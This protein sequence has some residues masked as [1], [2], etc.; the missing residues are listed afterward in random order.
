MLM[1]KQLLLFQSVH[2]VI[3]AE[4]YLEKKGIKTKIIAVPKS[5]SSECG[6]CLIFENGRAEEALSHLEEEGFSVECITL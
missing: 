4:K 3:K 5:I 1:K 6:M 2:W